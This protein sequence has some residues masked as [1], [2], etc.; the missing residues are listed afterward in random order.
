M[1]HQQVVSE[2]YLKQDRSSGSDF[3]S[4]IC[5]NT[6]MRDGFNLV[7]ILIV[8]VII[9]ILVAIIIPNYK[10]SVVRA[11]EAVLKENLFQLRDAI[12]KYYFDKQKYPETLDDLVASR[13]LRNIPTDPI[14]NQKEWH[15]IHPEPAEDEIYDPELLEGIMDV[16][17]LAPG[18]ALDGS[19]YFDW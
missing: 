10:Q 18:T 3:K 11:K 15:L 9:G 6:C 7:E 14:T 5:Y 16:K 19:N 4:K 17:S 8:M 2:N 12:S 1:R 13:Y